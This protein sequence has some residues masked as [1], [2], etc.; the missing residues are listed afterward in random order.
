MGSL[1][2]WPLTVFLPVCMHIA[3]HNIPRWSTKWILMHSLQVFCFFISL[4]AM[5]GSIVGVI[6]VSHSFCA[7]TPGMGVL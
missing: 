6:E 3:Q 2:F 4:T 1:G 5:I 7:H